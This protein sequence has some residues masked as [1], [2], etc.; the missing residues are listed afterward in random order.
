MRGTLILVVGPSGAGK[1]TLI[2]G[3]KA[4]MAVDA[5]FVFARRAITRPAAAGGEDHEPIDRAMFA[6]RRAA[7]EFLLAWQAHRLGY[8]IPASLAAALDAG[9]HVV[10]NVSRGV[11][12][13]AARHYSPVAAIEVT[14][15]PA[16]RAA[17]LAARGREGGD[18]VAARLARP[19]ASLPDGMK[20]TVVANEGA[21]AQG[22]AQ[23]V[24]AL[25]RIAQT[26]P[27]A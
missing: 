9:R 22:V 6:A 23:F 21:V 1:D 11:V 26:K 24:A 20:V 2:A 7:G 18:D 13:E 19:R 12:A 3:A 16:V 5:R 10:A 8:G 4:A 27:G 15:P 14:A 25:E 17:R